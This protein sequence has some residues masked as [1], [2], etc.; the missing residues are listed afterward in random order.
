MPSH[1]FEML[2]QTFGLSESDPEASL[3]ES[4]AAYRRYC[5]DCAVV[6]GV[7][8]VHAASTQ[9]TPVLAG[10]VSSEWVMADGADPDLRLLFVHGGS[11]IA[12]SPADHRQMTE[13][14]SR[15][16]G[17]V[18][19]APDYRL[20]PESPFPAGL[21]DCL[22]AWSWMLDH[23]PAAA[24][25][26]Q[27]NLM[28]GA[29]AGGGLALALMLRLRDEAKILPDAAVVFSPAADFTTS[30]PSMTERAHLDPT[31]KKED[32]AWAAGL[33]VSDG[34]ALTHPYVS[35]AFGDYSGLPPLMVFVGER[36]VM[37]DEAQLVVDKARQ[38]GV[39][40]HF[41]PQPGMVHNIEF[42][43]HYVPEGLASLKEAGAFLR[44]RI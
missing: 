31:I 28:S 8:P 2:L 18:V 20:A 42:W 24:A 41:K 30:S 16:T 25:K 29:S 17:A 40:A 9:V 13:A 34:T 33:Y 21:D 23:G 1:E 32:Y 39:E 3:E 19:L 7:A 44:D 37:H 10:G 26:S 22:A 38:A 27:A 43:C 14:L 11:F 5:A 12:G 4:I 35:P 15:E 36:E 6:D